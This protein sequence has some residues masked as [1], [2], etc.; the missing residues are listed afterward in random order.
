MGVSCFEIE[1]CEPASAR[2]I[3]FRTRECKRHLRADRRR[4][5]L[6]TVKTKDVAV[7]FCDCFGNSDI[8]ATSEFSH[9]LAGSPKLF[10]VSCDQVRHSTI[11]QRLI[12]RTEQRARST[13]SHRE[14][15]T[16]DISRR[17]KQICER[18]L[19]YS[20]QTAVSLL[21]SC[22]NYS[23]LRRNALSHTPQWC[24]LDLVD[25]VSPR[26]PLREPRLIQPVS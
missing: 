10:R 14:W 26:I 15:T 8:G 20:R 6:A 3:A 13:V 7:L 9:P 11:D 21:V 24:Q 2:W 22:S 25:A 5:P 12:T 18:A 16:V 17:C 19:M 1:K 4:E 23:M